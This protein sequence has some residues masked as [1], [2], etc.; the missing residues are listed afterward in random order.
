MATDY[1]KAK[2]PKP[3]F[4]TQK[5]SDFKPVKV[6]DFKEGLE[7]YTIDPFTGKISA[8]PVKLKG[9]FR[10]DAAKFADHANAGRAVV[11]VSKKKP[12]KAVAKPKAKAA[13]SKAKGNSTAENEQVGNTSDLSVQS[14]TDNG[15]IGQ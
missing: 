12:A 7:Y 14:N 2:A 3:V 9:N 4:R 8:E 6:G 10:L 11:K 13:K 15:G 5:A 1:R